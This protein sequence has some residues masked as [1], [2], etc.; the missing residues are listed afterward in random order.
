MPSPLAVLLA[1]TAAA[2]AYLAVAIR[3]LVRLDAA[4][5]RPS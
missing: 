2:L 1:L 5:A 4:E 3:Q